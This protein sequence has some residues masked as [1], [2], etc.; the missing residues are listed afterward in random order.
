MDQVEREEDFSPSTQF[1]HV[2]RKDFLSHS[3]QLDR[4]EREEDSSPFTQFDRVGGEG[5]C[6]SLDSFGLSRKG[7]A[8]P[9]V[10]SILVEERSGEALN[11]KTPM[12]L[13][14]MIRRYDSP[15][16]MEVLGYMKTN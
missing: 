15:V 8:F 7:W 6:L 9:L 13:W 11:K 16:A 10:Y 1:D 3:T 5:I 12:Q 4:V 2:G 14:T